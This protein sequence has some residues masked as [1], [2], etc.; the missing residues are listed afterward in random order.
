MEEKIGP[1]PEE[2]DEPQQEQELTEEE[3]II[4]PDPD[5]IY[6]LNRIS[7]DSQEDLAEAGGC[8]PGQHNWSN[9]FIFGVKRCTSCRSLR[10]PRPEVK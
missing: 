4:D 5:F 3:I 10:K 2:I 6:A 9:S 1:E 7:Y 8:P